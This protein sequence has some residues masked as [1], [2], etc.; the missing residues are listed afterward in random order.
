VTTTHDPYGA[1][2]P[3]LVLEK[4]DLW[5]GERQP[6]FWLTGQETWIGSDPSCDVVLP[7]LD[8]RHAV[9]VHDDA[10]E[11]VVRNCGPQARVHGAV[12]LTH[13][14]LRTGARLDLGPHSLSF[15]REE[16]A[17]HGRPFAG[18]VGGE[19]GHQR[20]QPSRRAA[21]G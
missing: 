16:Y 2:S 10:D 17:D 13:Q 21:R 18:R 1:G 19:A 9:V 20:R 4:R 7:G 11:Y 12:V 6:V 15:Y 3:R 14:I 5:A 8:P